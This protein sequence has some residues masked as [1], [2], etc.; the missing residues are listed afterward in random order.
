MLRFLGHQ[1]GDRVLKE[2]ALLITQ[3]TK[4]PGDLV[5]RFGGDE[6]IACF[7][8]TS[9][10]ASYYLMKNFLHSVQALSEDYK[11]S[12]TVS[13]GLASMCLMMRTV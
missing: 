8:N 9:R 7:S 13:I 2:I 5:G 1:Q 6:L 12:I 10:E 3:Y 4:R 11:V